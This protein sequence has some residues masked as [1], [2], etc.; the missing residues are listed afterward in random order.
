MNKFRRSR[1][2][3]F[4]VLITIL[5]FPLSQVIA[6]EY[7]ITLPSGAEFT[8]TKS[9][10]NTVLAQPGISFSPTLPTEI[11]AGQ[12]AVSIPKELGGGYIIGSAKSIA[13]AF[14]AAGITIG[15]TAGTITGLGL[16]QVGLAT[17]VGAFVAAGVAAAAGGLPGAPAA[18]THHPAPTHH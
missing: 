6:Q 12:V 18:P 8:V 2:F 13:G 15:A 11:P 7:T 9:Q 10:L 14:N 17:L 5:L 1:I 4:M 3:S 16:T